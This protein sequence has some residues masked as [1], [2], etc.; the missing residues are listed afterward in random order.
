MNRPYDRRNFL[1]AVGVGAASFALSQSVGGAEGRP[2]QGRRR[3]NIVFLLTDDQGYSDVGFHGNHL[4]K[5]PNL[6]KFA[7]EGVEFTQFYVAPVCSPTRACLMTG[8]YNYRTGVVD[9]GSGRAMMYPQEVTVAEA[10]REA[11]YATAIY[12]KWHLGDNHPTRPMDQ[13]FDESIVHVG[14]MIG[15]SYNPLDGNS[16]FNPIL[17]HNGVDKRYEGYCMDIYTDA[18][19]KFVEQHQEQPFLKVLMF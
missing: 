4:I 19:V 5:T 12:G 7:A 15:A 10:L 2:G 9:T 1:K 8:R 3:P 17:K 11:G 14:G 13:G 6:D 18:A 16:Y